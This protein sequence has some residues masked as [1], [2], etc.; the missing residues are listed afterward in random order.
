MK[1]DRRNLS[2]SLVILVNS[3]QQIFAAD[4]KGSA[5]S[6]PSAPATE[7]DKP[8][9]G[10]K[11][12]APTA[13][14]PKNKNNLR[15]I[16]ITGDEEA[17]KR[18]PG[19]TNVIG[20][21]TIEK[22]HQSDLQRMIWEVPGL[23]FQ[24]EDGYGLRPNIGMRGT[25]VL[26]SQK[27]TVMEDG[28]LIA[29]APY[30]APSIHSLPIAGRMESVE[31]RKGSSSIEY[32]PYTVGGAINLRS[33]SIPEAPWRAKANVAI[34]ERYGR[35]VH[36]NIGGS[37]KNFGWLLETYQLGEDGYKHIDGGGTNRLSA[38]DVMGK[39]RLNTDP[40]ASSYQELLLKLSVSG[41][42]SAES[43]LGLSQ[44]DFDQSP[45][46]VYAAAQKDQMKLSRQAVSLRHSIE[47]LPKSILTTT[48]YQQ[49]LNR[50]WYKLDSVK[51]GITASNI[52]SILS[53]PIKYSS[54][55]DVIRGTTSSADAL[56]VKANNRRFYSQ[57]AESIL[58]QTFGTATRHEINISLRLHKDEEDR[59]QNDDRY[60]MNQGYLVR[61]T[62]ATPGTG[63]GNNRIGSVAALAAYVIDNIEMGNWNL[64]VGARH[65]ALELNQDDYGASDP[66][67]VNTP[68]NK[69][70][71]I[72]QTLPGAGAAYRLTPQLSVF[73][74]VHRGFGPPTP[75]SESDTKPET[76]WNVETGVRYLSQIF[77]AE[78][79]GFYNSY[80]NI[81]GRDLYASGGQGTGAQFN[82][83][84]ALIKGAEFV[85][86]TDLGALIGLGLKVP[87]FANYTYTDARFESS[88]STTLEEWAPS[89]TKGD[90]MP[91]VPHG[92][93]GFGIGV[94]KTGYP[95][96]HII[97]HYQSRTRVQAGSTDLNRVE[98]I[99]SY[100][101]FDL[102]SG[103]DFA[104]GQ[105]LYID[106]RNVTARRYVAALRPA[107]VRPGMPRTVWAG[108]SL[109]L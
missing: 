80:E 91:F 41:E 31:V 40:D 26:R 99:P 44:A 50:N 59:L 56:T 74:G 93:G 69:Q 76:S 55:Y 103:Y 11:S 67:R 105:R 106:V 62:A 7:L 25:G 94:A 83:G 77:N 34:G 64:T 32:G 47:F 6:I 90:Y 85:V 92:M 1:L 100:A 10:G 12:T 24:D 42:N 35:R 73:T 46:R 82:G 84:K 65:E 88:F 8:S 58:S 9:Q 66:D 43:Y 68:T 97:G 57:G 86:R 70:S 49:K 54:E 13:G 38:Q 33:T 3:S 17:Q 71:K 101:V 16:T 89:V 52:K 95:D 51:T 20:Q 22:H 27:I 109:A 63:N 45:Y 81:L 79:T 29:P 78:F 53:D 104:P 108:I 5:I 48:V 102:T 60:Q 37:Q 107:G 36:L 19:S 98:A 14:I 4:L 87:T 72:A 21:D 39:M 61:T 2:L 30:A 15:G 96:L 28:I 18:T 75:G 23:Y